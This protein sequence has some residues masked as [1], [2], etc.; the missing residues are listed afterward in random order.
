MGNFN[1]EDHIV[2]LKMIT[3]AC[4]ILR[5]P[6]CVFTIKAFLLLMQN[7]CSVIHF[8]RYLVSL[9]EIVSDLKLPALRSTADPLSGP[10]D[11]LPAQGAIQLPSPPL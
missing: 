7:L 5:F 9:Y 10:L 2:V 8:K 4:W 11:M 1:D 6:P 3:A